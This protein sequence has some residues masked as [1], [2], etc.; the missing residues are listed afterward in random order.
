MKKFPFFILLLSL[1]AFLVGCSSVPY[2]SSFPRGQS[3]GGKTSSNLPKAGS[4][5]GGYY[6]DDGPMDYTPADL[7]NTPDAVPRVEPYA[8]GANKP[9]TVFGKRYVPFTDNRTYKVRGYGSWYGKKFH[10]KKT[11]N[12]EIYDMFK[13][14]AAHTTLPLPSYARVTNVSNGRQVIVRVND[15]GPFH[16]DRII[17]LS[18]TAALKLDYLSKGSTLLEVE[19]LLPDEIR[20]IN[21]G[22]TSAK[23]SE[24]M[25]SEPVAAPVRTT[26]SSATPAP[27]IAPVHTASSSTTTPASVVAPTHTASSST[28]AP[29]PIQET[30][31]SALSTSEKDDPIAKLAQ[32]ETKESVS[33]EEVL[34]AD[35]VLQ[36]GSFYIQLGAYHQVPYAKEAQAKY[37]LE[38]AHVISD[39]K[40]VKAGEYYRLY[41]GPYVSREAADAVARQIDTPHFHPLIIAR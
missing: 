16:S 9:Y 18:Y 8:K 37:A 15:R 33:Q 41:A 5:K 30:T 11:S 40:L 22:Q 21:A 29:A 25:D 14:S 19:R 13:M 36:A 17:D 12:G 1:C 28:T 3:S 38:W 31:P 39:I 32:E 20:R 7:E 34:E 10:G 27:A 2:V 6:Q 23:T 26:G 35:S 4:G 24:P